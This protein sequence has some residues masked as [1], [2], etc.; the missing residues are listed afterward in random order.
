VLT[1]ETEWQE[2]Q[3][4]KSIFIRGLGHLST[5]R[6]HKNTPRCFV[7]IKDRRRENKTTSL[8]ELEIC[9]IFTDLCLRLFVGFSIFIVK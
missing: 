4:R 8:E 2:E 6:T 5:Q 1:G 7:L 9:M 3:R